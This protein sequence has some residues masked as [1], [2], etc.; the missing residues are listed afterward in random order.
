[1]FKRTKK[2]LNIILI[3]FLCL[4]IAM[5]TP[6]MAATK[7][8]NTKKTIYAGETFNL[9]ISGTNKTIKWST[10]D[11]SIAS[12]KKVN[13]KKYK[14]TGKKQGKATITAKIGSKKYK[15]VVTVKKARNKDQTFSI[16]LKNGKTVKI[17]GHFEDDYAKEV[18]SQLNTYRK[19]KGKNTLK[20]NSS[21]TKAA[22]IRAYEIAYKF[23]HTRPNGKECYSLSNLISGENI[24]KGYMSPTAVMNGWKNS[25]EHN[26]NM[27][28]PKFK[29]IAVSCFALRGNKRPDGT[30][31]YTYCWVQNFGY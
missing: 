7:I 4:I 1:M 21:L 2:N 11:K 28:Y 3:L 25:S 14:I 31:Q 16:K 22:D 15:C 8:S 5:P 23:S 24:A 9:S 13:N 17:I 12:I 10:S 27:L 6:V 18:I 20:T 30:Y 29:K 19:S 26:K